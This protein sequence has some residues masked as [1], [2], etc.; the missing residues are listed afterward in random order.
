MREMKIKVSTAFLLMLETVKGK[1]LMETYCRLY[2]ITNFT[3]LEEPLTITRGIFMK[4]SETINQKYITS[5]D[6]SCYHSE[7]KFLGVLNDEAS[8]DFIQSHDFYKMRNNWED[9]KVTLEAFGMQVVVIPE[10]AEN[11]P[12]YCPTCGDSA[13]Q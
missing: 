13:K 1:M 3:V 4:T 8:A 11:N 10:A 7:G 12:A 6:I 2:N 5:I 9:F